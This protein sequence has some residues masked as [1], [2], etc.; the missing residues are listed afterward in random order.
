MGG[1]DWF[2]R[3]VR[4]CV[5]MFRIWSVSVV[6]EGSVSGDGDGWV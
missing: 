6:I 5:A 3:E 4:C 2:H 1:G